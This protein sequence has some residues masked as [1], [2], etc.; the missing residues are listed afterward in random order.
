MLRMRYVDGMVSSETPIGVFVDAFGC[1]GLSDPIPP[2]PSIPHR[3]PR[4]LSHLESTVHTS[5]T[6]HRNSSVHVPT[7]IVK[8]PIAILPTVVSTPN[9]KRVALELAKQRQA[10]GL[11]GKVS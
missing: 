7:S 1:G 8:V 6:V 2:I 11:P 4:N 5:R 9:R 10:I 3:I